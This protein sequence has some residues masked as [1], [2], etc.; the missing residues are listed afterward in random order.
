MRV[1]APIVLTP[2]EQQALQAR[3]DAFR[4]SPRTAERA[5]IVLLAAQGLQDKEIA[6]A[7]GVSA[8]KAARWRSR[9][10]AQGVEGLE[11]DAPRSGRSPIPAKTVEK[12][13]WMTA[14][15]Q[16]ARA[17]RWST[18]SM[19][20]AVGLSEASIRRIWRKHGLKPHR[21]RP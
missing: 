12:I 13:L 9:F 16:P 19:A 18:R 17:P 20:A 11:R 10:L 3:L 6:E 15:Q 1:A 14:H 5:R 7:L 8:Q 21:K 2:P 4:S